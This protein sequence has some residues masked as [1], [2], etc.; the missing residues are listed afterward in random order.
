MALLIKLSSSLR[1]HVAGYEPVNGLAYDLKPGQNVAQVMDD[2]GIPAARV[3]IV[4]V[5]GV[6]SPV[7]HVLKDGD[8]LALF[9]AVGGG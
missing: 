2:L 9:P 3:K 1:R 7:D 4:M 5:N 8:R 6:S